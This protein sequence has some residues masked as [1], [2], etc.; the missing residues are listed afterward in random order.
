MHKA[1]LKNAGD[2]T[3]VFRQRG[4]PASEHQDP[5]RFVRH[6]L[7]HDVRDVAVC[8]EPV[9]RGI[10]WFPGIRKPV[11]AEQAGNARDASRTGCIAGPWGFS[12]RVLTVGILAS[13]TSSPSCRTPRSSW[14][15]RQPCSR[16]QRSAFAEALGRGARARDTGVRKPLTRTSADL[17]LRGRQ[18]GSA[19]KQATS[20]LAGWRGAGLP[21]AHAHARPG[22]CL[23]SHRPPP[24]PPP[25][26][27]TSL[28]MVSS[29]PCG[30][31]V[32]S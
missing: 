3:H 12:R 32:R 21:P 31:C 1:G 10:F 22:R 4:I 25:S 7:A 20:R 17:R 15:G 26:T 27:L 18:G 9:E 14:A 6:E 16:S 8:L 13:L 23:L 24:H 5:G 11:S 28:A 2:S 30:A 29:L 19:G